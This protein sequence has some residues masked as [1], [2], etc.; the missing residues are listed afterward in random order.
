MK[1]HVYSIILLVAGLPVIEADDLKPTI[2][3]EL[4]A[5]AERG[6]TKAQYEL[7]RALLRGEGVAKDPAKAFELMKAAADQGFADALGGVGYF[8]NVGQVVTKDQKQAVEWFRKGAEKGSARSQFNLGTVLL[9]TRGGDAEESTPSR[10]EGL[11]W[12]LKSAEQG[13]PEAAWTYGRALF[14]GRFGLAKEPQKALPFMELAAGQGLPAAQNMLGSMYETGMGC[15]T[16]LVK[17]TNWYQKAAL[18]GHLKAQAN[19]GRI[20]GPSSENPEKRCEALAWLLMAMS[21]GEVTAEKAL[22]DA[23]PGLKDGEMESARTKSAELRKHIVK[24]TAN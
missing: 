16:D 11:Q 21:Q 15:E 14:Q 7:A 24:P 2:T 22:E 8:Y 17:A 10:Q 23:A 1:L 18:Q 20:L 4:Q 5:A 9:D 12:I 19:L 13:F 6:D 3:S